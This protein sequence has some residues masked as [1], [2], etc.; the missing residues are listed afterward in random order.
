VADLVSRIPLKDKYALFANTASGVPELGVPPYQWWNEALHGVGGSP[1]VTFTGNT[2]N[3]TS[4]PMPCVTG[5]AFDK[6]LWAAIGTAIGTEARAFANEGHA[7]L[8]FWTPNLNIFRYAA[9]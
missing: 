4:F 9:P 7:G 6:E 1:G 3:A 5:A 8:T 2:P